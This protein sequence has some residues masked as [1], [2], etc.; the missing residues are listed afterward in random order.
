MFV[1]QLAQDRTE[2]FLFPVFPV[3]ANTVCCYITIVC[4]HLF[5]IVFLLNSVV[6]M[7]FNT[8]DNNTEC[9]THKEPNCSVFENIQK[10]YPDNKTKKSERSGN[11][12]R[13]LSQNIVA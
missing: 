3:Y 12:K 4:F 10:K 11:S 9:Y 5:F 2:M 8:C 13:F 6:V 1:F 7:I